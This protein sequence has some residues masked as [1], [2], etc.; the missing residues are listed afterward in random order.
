MS[1][2]QGEALNQI[3]LM[4]RHDGKELSYT[5]YLAEAIVDV[6][7]TPIGSRVGRRNYGSRLFRL[8]DSNVTRYLPLQMSNAIAD[9]I[10]RNLPIVKVEQVKITA[11]QLSE[12]RVICTLSAYE[13]LLGRRLDLQD[14]SLDFFVQ[15]ARYQ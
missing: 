2:L 1:I 8:L 13:T 15:N 14:L 7:L 9:A 5:D 10:M 11:L 12:G 4:S 3:V 6:L